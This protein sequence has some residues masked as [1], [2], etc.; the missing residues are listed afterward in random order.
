[1]TADRPSPFRTEIPK[2]ALLFF[3]YLF[4]LDAAPAQTA[5]PHASVR[6]VFFVDTMFSFWLLLKLYP[7]ADGAWRKN[8]RSK[9]TVCSKTSLH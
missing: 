3:T 4:T 7:D 6:R 8:R 2:N 9:D 1:M 5:L